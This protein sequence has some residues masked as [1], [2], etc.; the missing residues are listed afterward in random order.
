[1]LCH[2]ATMVLRGLK[3]VLGRYRWKIANAF[4]YVCITLC[5]KCMLSA[6]FGLDIVHYVCGTLCLKYIPSA[7]FSLDVVHY[8]CGTLCLKDSPFSTNTAHCTYF[9]ICLLLT[10]GRYEQNI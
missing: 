3:G 9:C 2:M 8:V 1:M 5:L 4:H 7:T 6:T 10:W